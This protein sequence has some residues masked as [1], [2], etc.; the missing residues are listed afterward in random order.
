MSTTSWR[1]S[2]RRWPRRAADDQVSLLLPADYR[3]RALLAQRGVQCVER[4]ADVLR[5][6]IVNLMPNALQYEALLLTALREVSV[7]VEPI[8]IRL[9]SHSYGSSDHEALKRS[10]VSYERACELGIGG[11]ILTG[12]P[13]EEL[14]FADVH[15]W[16]ELAA[17]LTHARTHLRSTLGLCWGGMALG[18]L[19]GIEKVAY[20][21]KLFGSFELRAAPRRENLAGQGALWCMQSRHAGLDDRALEA[22]EQ[23]GDV[24]LLASSQRVGHT[25][26]E[27]SDGR[28]VAH[29]GHPEYDRERI[30][31]EYRRD[32]AAGRDDVTAPEGVALDG[33]AHAGEN[34]GPAFFARF[35]ARLA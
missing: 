12:A 13:V 17:L 7:C 22:A 16:P 2:S 11:L 23:R 24:Q 18:Q 29:L 4:R 27:S 31:F 32:R 5:V 28:Y 10:Y 9:A 30:L 1:T 15:Y 26:F 34:H 19:L 33:H 35:F 3:H 8:W 6:G 21:H 14:A 25:L 20:S